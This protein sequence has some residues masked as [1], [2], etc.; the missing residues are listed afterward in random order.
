M[1]SFPAKARKFFPSKASRLAQHPTPTPTEWL[2]GD[3][4]VGKASET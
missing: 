3:R 4:S 2:L 1:F